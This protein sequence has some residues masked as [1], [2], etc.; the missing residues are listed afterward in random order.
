M[1]KKTQT[2]KALLYVRVSSAPQEE[3]GYSLDAQKQHGADYAQSKGL[4]IVRVWTGT[5]SAWKLDREQFRELID[6]A[7]H[8]PEVRHI[9]FD[10][11]D[12]M[13]RNDF[14][15][16]KILKLTKEH[17]K[18]IHFA[19]TGKVLDKNS[20]SDDLFMLDIEVAVAKK[21]SED[22]SRKA[23]MGLNEKARQGDY[24]GP[25][26]VGYMNKG[27][28]ERKWIEIERTQSKYVAR[29][30]ELMATGNYSLST[31]VDKLQDDGFR[32][33]NG[34]RIYKSTLQHILRNPIY[35]GAFRWNGMLYQGNHEA[36]VAK[37]LFERVQMILS[38]S[39]NF[40]RPRTHKFAFNNLME[41]AY[42]GCKVLGERVKEKY[43]YYHC[44]FSKG[45]HSEFKKY[46]RVDTLI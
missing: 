46:V 2:E 9:I 25:A 31:L 45:R 13:T 40:N 7:E 18:R 44:S 27:D 39:W 16:L 33:K 17:D 36:V 23:I 5:E 3:E 14:D 11:P 29:A 30:F 6:Y 28:R 24:P 1:K 21:M 15:K 22:I 26:P 41:C 37:S 12:R 8:H 4:E 19:R 43:I 35:Y 34:N 38:G 42:C 32:S 10:V 20:G